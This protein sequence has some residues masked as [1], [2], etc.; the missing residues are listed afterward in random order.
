MTTI[1]P[2]AVI[3][4]GAVIGPDCKIGPYCIIG[5]QVR[6]GAGVHLHSHVVIDGI[7]EIGESTE[8]Y[9]FTALGSAPQDLKYK[10][11]KSRLI[12]GSH[13]RIREHVT[14][15][16]GTE[17]GGMETRVGNHGLFMVGVH[18]AHDCIIG[19]Y[20]VMANNATLAGHVTVGDHAI[21]GG[22]AAAHQFVRI[23]AYSMIGGMSGVEADVIPYGL[24]VGDRAHLSGLNLIGLKRH[25]IKRSVI[26]QLRKACDQ[27]FD[28]P[29]QSGEQQHERVQKLRHSETEQAVIDLLDFI[30]GAEHRRGLVQPRRT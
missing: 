8:V 19:D 27:I 4:D 23:G 25:G 13:N 30:D 16:P 22:L 10:G 17:G 18:I 26:S 5:P 6:L 7:T 29:D 28:D 3:H 11:E 12:V 21:I 9:P 20:V 2:T 14:M 24:V 15:N 1:H